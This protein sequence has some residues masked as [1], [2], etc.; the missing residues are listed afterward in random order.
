MQNERGELQVFVSNLFKTFGGVDIFQRCFENFWY[1]LAFYY[2]K[3]HR[4]F[5]DILSIPL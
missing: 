5:E 2:K 1:F 3:D 4:D